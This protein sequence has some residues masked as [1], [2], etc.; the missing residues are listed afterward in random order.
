MDFIIITMSLTTTTLARHDLRRAANRRCQRY[1]KHP[2]RTAKNIFDRHLPHSVVCLMMC[3]GVVC[4][5]F[6]QSIRTYRSVGQTPAGA[7]RSP[8]SPQSSV[9]RIGSGTQRG[10][11]AATR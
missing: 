4:C 6:C 5:A 11:R 1:D 3:V 8:A 2:S 10:T 7:F 9:G